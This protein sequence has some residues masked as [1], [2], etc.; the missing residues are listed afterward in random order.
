LYLQGC[1]ILQSET[2]QRRIRLILR[3]ESCRPKS[4]H[5]NEQ[6]W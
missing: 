1:K 6:T 3:C 2:W 5:D 4:G